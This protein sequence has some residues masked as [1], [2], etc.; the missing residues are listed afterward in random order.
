MKKG[1]LISKENIKIV[2]PGLSL[3]PI[4]YDEIIGKNVNK[5]LSVGDRVT[6]DDLT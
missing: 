1:E 5:D 4:F 2:R 3:S 6:F